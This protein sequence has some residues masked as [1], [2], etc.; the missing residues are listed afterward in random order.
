[1]PII[2]PRPNYKFFEENHVVKS[3]GDLTEHQLQPLQFTEEETDTKKDL[4]P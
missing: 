4:G 2:A 3:R 1:M